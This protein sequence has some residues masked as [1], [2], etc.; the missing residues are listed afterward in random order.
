[1]SWSF[2]RISHDL[3]NETITL[4]LFESVADGGV[5][6]EGALSY[7]GCHRFGLPMFP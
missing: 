6:G 2:T 1:M 3:Q 5:R 7:G 4:G